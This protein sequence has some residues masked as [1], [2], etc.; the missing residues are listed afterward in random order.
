MK[1]YETRAVVESEGQLHLA[2]IPFTAGTEVE[3][4]VN[5]KRQSPQEFAAAW[6]RVCAEIRRRS[7]E[8][9]EDEIQQEIDA[10]RSTQ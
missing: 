8:V 5:P 10:C 7:G 9:S 2:G 6:N 3:V 1:A 4:T